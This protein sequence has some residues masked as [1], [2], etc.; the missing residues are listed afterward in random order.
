M[1]GH[2]KWH[3][4]RRS[5]GIL[6][7]RRGQLFTKLAR[8]ITIAAREGGSGDP[9]SNFRLRIAVDKA[10]GSNM[11]ADNIQRA[12]DRGLGKGGE[13]ALEEIYYEGYAPGGIA[14]LIETATD[15]R[16][17]TNAEVRATLTKAGGSP[18]EPGSVGWLF[19]QKGLITID[20]TAKSLDPEELMLQAIDAGADDVE[21]GEDTL[22]IYTDFKQ[23]AAVRQKLLAAGLALSG[24]EKIML[25]KTTIKSEGKEALQA[26]RLMEK[27]EDLDDVQKV[28]SNLDVS[29]ELAEQFANE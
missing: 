20:L 12:I 13:S 29:E 8:D 27:L 28:Y 7:Q 14:I 17:R 18:G 4:I 23:F 2:S 25:P 1:S 5:K 22:E 21:V 3:S 24:A 11:P 9:D 26:M 15:N 6:D 10:K 16:N 19:E